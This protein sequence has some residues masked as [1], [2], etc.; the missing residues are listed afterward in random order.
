MPILNFFSP[1][2]SSNKRKYSLLLVHVY[3][4]ESGKDKSST[5]FAAMAELPNLFKDMI[6]VVLYRIRT[7]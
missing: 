5:D 7:L 4:I 1:G 6:M 3:N 2:G